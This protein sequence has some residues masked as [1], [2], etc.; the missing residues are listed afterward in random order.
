MRWFVSQS[1]Y[2]DENK[3]KGKPYQIEQL[4]KAANVQLLPKE[5]ESLEMIADQCGAKVLGADT[6]RFAVKK[7]IWLGT[8]LSIDDID[9]VRRKAEYG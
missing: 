8:Q 2:C 6:F 1:K 9:L 5:I 4:S 3:S 7:Q